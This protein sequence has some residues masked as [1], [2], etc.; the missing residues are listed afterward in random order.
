MEQE[1]IKQSP[2][3]K[4]II[5]KIEQ[6]N[7]TPIARWHFTLRNSGFWSL[8]G[9]SILIGSC[10]T[11]A[12]IFTFLHS[13]W[14]YRAVTHDSFVRFFFDVM[15]LF[16]LVSLGAMIVF[17]YYNIRH[18]Q[19]GYRFSF[20]LI[21]LASVVASFIGGT[22]L[23]TLGVA[24]DIDGIRKPLPFSNPVVHL[25][26]RHWNDIERGLIAG[27]VLDF[28]PG[29]TVVI[30][31]LFSGNS[32]SVSL[33]SLDE[34]SRSIIQPGA[35]VRII[36]QMQ[37]PASTDAFIACVVLPW[38]TESRPVRKDI[39]MAK[40]ELSERKNI[41]ERSSICKDVRPYNRYKELLITK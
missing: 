39:F 22:L 24:G 21:I 13:G 5:N 10:A 36:G 12:S 26:E 41:E 29:D 17:G 28:A 3:A 18:T 33:D 15:P 35:R 38:D 32:Q 8:W 19:R 16:W 25:E 30:V 1:Y 20:F 31:K 27:E 2:T 23:Y 40:E 4:Q 11:A 7:M 6:G 9:V 37:D 34:M 14:Q